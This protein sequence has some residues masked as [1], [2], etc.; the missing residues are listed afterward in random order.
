MLTYD[1]SEVRSA[2]VPFSG[3]SNRYLDPVQGPVSW[4]GFDDLPTGARRSG[5]IIVVL[6]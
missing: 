5:I 2:L 6:L 3:I 4:E 1:E